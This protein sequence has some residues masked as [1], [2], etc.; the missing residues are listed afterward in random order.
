MLD[1]LSDAAKKRLFVA[2][3]IALVSTSFAFILRIMILG[4][5]QKEF[6][7]TETQKGEI[8]GVGIWPFAVSII[9]FSL[10]IDRIGY[11][12]AILFAFVG[13]VGFAVLTIFA[14]GYWSL[15]VGSLLGGLAAGSIEAAINPVVATMYSR[16]KTK[17]LNILHAGW[18]GGLLAAG[19]LSIAMGDASWK[20][21]VG[22]IFLPVVGYGAMMMT[23]RFPVSE[24]V[25]AGVS[26]K[27]MLRQAGWLGALVATTLVVMEV[28]RVFDM[29][30]T[31]IWIV[32]GV[33]VASFGVYT[34]AAGNLLFFVLIL[35][36]MPL[37][38]TEL[39]TDSWIT[40]LMGPEM[41]AIGINAAWVLVYTSL[42]MMVLRF[43]AGPIVH[44]LQPLGLLAVSAALAI[45]GLFLLSGAGG[46]MILV[47]ATIYGV[48]KTF[49]WP[50]MLG[51]V[52]EQCPKGGA[53]TLNMISGIGMLAA[54]VIGNPLLGNIQDKEIDAE[55]LARAPAIHAQVAGGEKRSVF[56]SYRA[57]DEAKVAALP[58]ESQQTVKHVKTVAKK[59]AL[60]TVALFPV[61]MLVV[62]LALI[63][64]F[65]AR[66]GYRPVELAAGGH[67]PPASK[68]PQRTASVRP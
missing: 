57:I 59:S 18:P 4:D 26:H 61:S 43:V 31:A 65:R 23:S 8:L 47:A 34:G 5:L 13:H 46:L 25:A 29:D 7:L 6:G 40:D 49:F 15:Y 67:E 54:G 1:N 36:M 17:W 2:C 37:A 64:W 42:I 20:W 60:Q 3:F 38:I 55:L 48:G 16:E 56:G 66:G 11:G 58:A 45:A 24:R 10:V 32:I 62:Y 21:K 22:L 68:P 53:L 52:S 51:V 35:T 12:K 27:D 44:R 63:G 39:G 33:I 41:E 30:Q 19:V 14:T 9:L 28:G 50:T